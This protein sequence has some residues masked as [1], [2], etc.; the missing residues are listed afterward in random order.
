MTKIAF[1]TGASRGIGRAI[2]C[3]L[4]ES[5]YDVA[6]SARKVDEHLKATAERIESLG[7]R[8]LMVPLDLLD[9]DSMRAASSLSWPSSVSLVSW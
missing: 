5:G 2:A 4:A 7:K 9:R 8:S 3:E 6:I 1:V